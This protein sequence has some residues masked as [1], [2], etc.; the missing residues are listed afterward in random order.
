MLSLYFVLSD[1]PTSPLRKE[2]SAEIRKMAP[3]DGCST[4]MLVMTRWNNRLIAVHSP[5]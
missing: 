5:S 2:G 3:E 1:I 4:D